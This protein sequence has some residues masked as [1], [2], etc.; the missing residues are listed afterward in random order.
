MYN[1]W[2]VTMEQLETIVIGSTVGVLDHKVQTPVRVHL[3]QDETAERGTI[4]VYSPKLGKYVP[5]VIGHAN[6]DMQK[7]NVGLAPGSWY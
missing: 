7:N 4:T 6:G 2:R 3:L 5:I 1:H